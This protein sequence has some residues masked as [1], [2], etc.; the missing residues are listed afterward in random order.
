[1]WT[2]MAGRHAVLALSLAMLALAGC[3]RASPPAVAVRTATIPD[4]GTGGAFLDTI[5]LSP[6]GTRVATGERGGVIRVW[7]P[8]ASAEPLRLGE[9]RQ[10]IADL[11]FAPDGLTLASIGR[12]RES[13]LRLWQDDGAGG[14]KEV[15][16][17]PSGR[18]LALRFD[19]KGTR[20]AVMCEDEV[21]ILEV[22][23]RQETR[24]LPKP[25]VEALTAFDLSA[26]GTRLLTAG[27]EGTVTVWELATVTPVPARSF[28]VRRSRRASPPPAGLAPDTAWAVAAALSRDG[29][30]AAAVTIEG[31]VFVW[32][33]DRGVELLADADNE[34]T[35]PPHGS[36]RFGDDGRLLAPTGDRMGFHL[37]DVS[38]KGRKTSNP[39]VAGAKAFHAASVTDD[40]GRFAVLTS[41][42]GYRQLVYDVEVWRVDTPQSRPR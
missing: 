5:A 8:S 21:L 33:L 20:L 13:T 12:H 37:L 31:T 39:L 38:P 41:T 34:A 42:L 16:A 24:R 27:H 35:G 40:A 30:R 32:D 14:W 22:A 25:H 3:Q 19:A 18:C 6:D 23:T 10:A 29:R 1:M 17:I 9:Y 4:V 36:L 15:A 7:A 11:A 2:A 28:S 26:D